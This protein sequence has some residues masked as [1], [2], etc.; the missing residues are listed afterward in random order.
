MAMFVLEPNFEA[1]PA[2]PL[3]FAGLQDSGHPCRATLACAETR[4]TRLCWLRFSGGYGLCHF[5]DFPLGFSGLRLTAQ[6]FAMY[7]GM[8]MRPLWRGERV[9]K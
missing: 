4:V 1:S 3:G 9:R 2:S 6:S 7:L 5:G 8:T